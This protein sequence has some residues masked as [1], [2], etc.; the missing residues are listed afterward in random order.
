MAD[1]VNAVFVAADVWLQPLATVIAGALAVM[2]AAIAYRAVTRQIKANAENVQKQIDATAAEQ[3]KN[4]AADWAKMRRREVL[5]LVLEAGNIARRLESIGHTYAMREGVDPDEEDR[6]N[7]AF[8]EFRE[9]NV[10]D[11]LPLV[12]E[13][14]KMHGLTAP[15]EAVSRLEIEVGAVMQD[16]DDGPTIHAR[17]QAVDD[18][19][20]KVLEDPPSV[21]RDSKGS[22]GFR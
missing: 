6:L 9:L 22:F 10:P 13:N 12:M 15:A 1:A 18:A 11:R 16:L 3:Q 4:R 2:A 14:L 8:R 20:E 21:F 17:R 19:I 5:D 7:A